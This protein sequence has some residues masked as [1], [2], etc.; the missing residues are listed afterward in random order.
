MEDKLKGETSPSDKDIEIS[1][2]FCQN[3]SFQEQKGINQN[4]ELASV[5]PL[6]SCST[7]TPTMTTK[8]NPSRQIRPIKW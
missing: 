5:A 7:A 6:L 2:E 8:V 4:Q 1:Y 3:E